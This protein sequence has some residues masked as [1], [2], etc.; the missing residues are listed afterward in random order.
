MPILNGFAYPRF[1]DRSICAL[2]LSIRVMEEIELQRIR[3]AIDGDR[4]ACSRLFADSWTLVY[5]WMIG[6]TSD[7]VEAE[8]LTQQTFLRAFTRL[9]RLRDPTR[10]FPWLRK[11]GRTV[12]LNRRRRR[13]LLVREERPVVSPAVAAEGREARDG[14]VRALD[15]LKPAD[16][17]LL[18]LAYLEEVPVA[19]IAALL[20]RPVTTTRRRI[21]AALDRFR[22][23][24]GKEKGGRRGSA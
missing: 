15:R 11:V 8:D 7:R 2:D 19:R 14:V 20:D 24:Y 13:P 22:R 12:A 4:V 18:A 1:A 21:L 5:A 17:S 10:F 23:E 3:A 16:R 9:S 6:F